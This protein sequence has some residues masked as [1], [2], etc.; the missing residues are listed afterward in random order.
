MKLL[1]RQV[2]SSIQSAE[3]ILKESEIQRLIIQN[4]ENRG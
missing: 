2:T 4:Q 3:E 1:H